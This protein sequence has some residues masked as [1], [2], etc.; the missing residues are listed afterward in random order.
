M[1]RKEIKE[2]KIA[3]TANQ[4]KGCL[5]TYELIQNV[6]ISLNKFT[7]LRNRILSIQRLKK[8]VFLLLNSKIVKCLKKH[9][10]T[11]KHVLNTH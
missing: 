7:W 3:F 1:I 5:T 8:V 10:Q 4:Q 6:A 9:K 11:L 2:K